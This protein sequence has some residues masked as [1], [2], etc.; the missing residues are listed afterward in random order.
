MHCIAFSIHLQFTPT[1]MSPLA[2]IEIPGSING[3]SMKGCTMI[4]EGAS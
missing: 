1:L 4:T 3:S 2:E